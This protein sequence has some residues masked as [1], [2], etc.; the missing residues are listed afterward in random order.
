MQ[1]SEN[2]TDIGLGL[3]EQ[4]LCSVQVRAKSF[5]LNQAIAQDF[6]QLV[7]AAKDA[8]FDLSIASS[9]RD[10]HRQAGIFAAKFEGKR[11][12]LDSNSQVLDPSTLSDKEKLYAILRWSALPGASRHHF[13]TDLDVY[14]ANCLPEGVNLQL[15]PWEY[16][17]G[18]QKEFAA[19]LHQAMPEFGFFL[20]YASDRGGVAVEPWHISHVQTA[21]R[22]QRIVTPGLLAQ[23][24]KQH[25]FSGSDIALN[26]IEDIYQRF[27]INIT[28]PTSI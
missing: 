11:A 15:E 9:F 1:K 25:P 21:S 26:Y 22:L 28:P 8:G 16:Q 20:P 27:I 10:Y 6:G 3:T 23:T 7:S 24:W 19:W 18:H 12:I 5:L 2:L 4:H 17:T 14:A 13:G